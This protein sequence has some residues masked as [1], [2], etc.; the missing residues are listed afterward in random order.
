MAKIIDKIEYAMP[1]EVHHVLGQYLEKL[2][3]GA[4]G[5]FV[6]IVDGADR[7]FVISDR[8]EFAMKYALIEIGI[9]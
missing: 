6:T 8:L 7:E 9:K 4:D 2:D 1:E 5:R 3:R